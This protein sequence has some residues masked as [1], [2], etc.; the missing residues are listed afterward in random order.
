MGARR[1]RSGDQMDP[2]ILR[3]GLYL[4]DLVFIGKR[5]GAGFFLR[6]AGR[7]GSRDGPRRQS[8]PGGSGEQN[9]AGDKPPGRSGENNTSASIQY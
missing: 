2:P 3:H 6:A 1:H 7:L 4:E 5:K 8:E 9:S